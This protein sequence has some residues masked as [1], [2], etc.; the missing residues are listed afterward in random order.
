MDKISINFNVGGKYYLSPI[1]E[2]LELVSKKYNF[3][4]EED[5][6]LPL[7]SISIN[8]KLL[9]FVSYGDG[10]GICKPHLKI[11]QDH[12]Y[13]IL[14]KYHYSPNIYDV[15]N[16]YD[17]IPKHIF[18]CGLWRWWSDIEFDKNCLLNKDR[19]IDIM[20]RMICS[21]RGTRSNSKKSWVIARHT[22]IEKAKLMAKDGY[23]VHAGKKI[24]I[25]EY[26]DA[27]LNTKIGFLWSASAYLGW[28][29]PEFTQTG[30]VMI[31]EPLGE[32]YPLVNNAIFEHEKHCVFE[33]NPNNFGKVAKQLLNHPEKLKEIRK[34]VLEL[35]EEK[36]HPEKVGSYYYNI[37]KKYEGE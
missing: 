21:N 36:L 4:I 37:L 18:A 22:L 1:H 5:D 33:T 14:F 11:I 34:N 15:A 10:L 2:S 8:G 25:N 12:D 7:S 13:K 3:I 26:K 24:R 19:N 28:K 6:K 16:I 30:V 23:N 9:A 31:T 27:L 17:N 20:S 29:I 35:W 32:N